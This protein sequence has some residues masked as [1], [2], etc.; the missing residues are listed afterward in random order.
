MGM[1][2]SAFFWSYSFAQVPAGWLVDRLGVGR[3][4][5][6][7]FAVWT[8]AVTATG[9]AST[10]AL[11]V[12]L[13]LMGIGQSVAFPASAR[14][15][16]NWFPPNERGAVTGVYLA[17]NRLGQAAI[18]GIG[19]AI[20]A[21][22]GWQYLFVWAGIAGV[23]WLAPWIAFHWRYERNPLSPAVAVSAGI[24]AAFVNLTWPL[25]ML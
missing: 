19:G 17:G 24:S 4:Y 8:A 25:L 18:T 22:H 12:G 11:L 6:A 13:L 2:L 10:F 21:T 16:A 15:V 1:L 20:I 7:G 9:L 3:A 23:L 14:A 5:A